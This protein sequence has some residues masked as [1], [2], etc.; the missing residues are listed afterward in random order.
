MYGHGQPWL[1]TCVQVH[2][3]EGRS[4]HAAA[5]VAVRGNGGCGGRE[6]QARSGCGPLVV[7]VRWQAACDS[8]CSDQQDQASIMT[9]LLALGHPG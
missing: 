7:V 5:D 2:S 4:K 9:G 8:G 6:E 1:Y 3:V